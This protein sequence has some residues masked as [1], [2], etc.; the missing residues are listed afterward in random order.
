MLS[1]QTKTSKGWRVT[2]HA[3]QILLVN[4]HFKIS[5][6][7]RQKVIRERRK[8][9]HAY[10]IGYPAHVERLHPNRFTHSVNYNPYTGKHFHTFD[11]ESI[12]TATLVWAKSNGLILIQR[13]E[14]K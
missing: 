8:N 14:P 10:I 5:E 2:E 7:G 3:Y 4:A 13:Y 9:V 1:I 12:H 6:A 11:G